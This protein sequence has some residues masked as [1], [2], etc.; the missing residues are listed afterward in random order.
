MYFWGTCKSARFDPQKYHFYK[1]GSRDVRMSLEWTQLEL[2]TWSEFVLQR[3]PFF[4]FLVFW[5]RE[6]F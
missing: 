5:S 3:S 4:M 6:P 1:V 2:R